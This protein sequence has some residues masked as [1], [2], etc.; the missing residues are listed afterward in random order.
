MLK[1]DDGNWLTP[2]S[3][4]AAIMICV[5]QYFI[6]VYAPV[7]MT[8]GPVQKIFYPHIGLAW[9][10]LFSFLVVFVAGIGFLARRTPFWDNLGAAAAEVGVLFSGLA[11]VLGMIWGKASWGVWWTWDPRLTTTL[12]MWF[13]YC[14]YLI[15]RASGL[16]GERRATVTAVVG[17]VAFLDVP[18]VFLSARMWRSIHPSVFKREGGGLEPEMLTTMFVCLAA[19]GLLWLAMTA[20]RARQ[21]GQAERLDAVARASVDG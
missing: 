8:M 18:L 3:I 7:E 6:W 17:I 20:F 1:S 10:S 11:L 4:L 12:V 15:L 13:V 5:A 9:W 2:V 14:G 16:G 21:L 19:F